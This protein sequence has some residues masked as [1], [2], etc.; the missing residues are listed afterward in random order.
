[1]LLVE[2]VDEGMMLDEVERPAGLRKWATTRPTA[3]DP[4]TS[5]ATP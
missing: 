1:V 2:D 5:T 4:A 3:A